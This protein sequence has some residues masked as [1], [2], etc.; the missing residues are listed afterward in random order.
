M[1]Q[2]SRY[3]ELS[4]YNTQLEGRE[5]Y[6]HTERLDKMMFENTEEYTTIKL[7]LYFN[8]EV[9]EEYNRGIYSAIVR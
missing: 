8:P 1:N 6:S 2:N 3:Y 5:R 7:K 4:T 9:E